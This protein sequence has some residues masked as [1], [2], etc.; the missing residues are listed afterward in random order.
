MIND[1]KHK[2]YDYLQH[3]KNRHP[4]NQTR[5]QNCSFE[6][7]VDT[8][9]PKFFLFALQNCVHFYPEKLI[10]MFGAS[11]PDRLISAN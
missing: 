9:S 6:S 10:G 5:I 2:K 4:M 7:E 1:K 8:S 3:D 11:F